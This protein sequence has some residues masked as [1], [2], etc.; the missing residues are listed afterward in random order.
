MDDIVYDVPTGFVV[1]CATAVVVA[2]T[3]VVLR[4]YWWY[5]IG[6]LSAFFEEARKSYAHSHRP[7]RIILIRHGESEGNVEKSVYR[8]KADNQLELTE[9]GRRQAR[10]AGEELKKLIGEEKI[11]FYCSPVTRTRQTFAEISKSFDQKQYRLREDPRLREQEWGNY[12]NPDQMRQIEADRLSVGRFYYRFPEGESGADVYDR[13][14]TFFESLFREIDKLGFTKRKSFRYENVVIVSHGLT[15]RLI[16]MRYFRWT[17]EEFDE[18]YNARNCEYYVLEKGET[19]YRL[20]TKLF[21]G[22]RRRSLS[23]VPSMDR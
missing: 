7:K 16:L 5:F 17:V 8:R 4:K 13:V 11:M 22:C 10:A 15:M 2:T 6:Y 3:L 12:Q 9:R 1:S 18:V 14:S 19:S 21:R 20:V 23:P